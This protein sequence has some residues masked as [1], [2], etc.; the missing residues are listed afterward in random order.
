MAN[1]RSI[2]EFGEAMKNRINR[3]AE[4]LEL[5]LAF[6]VAEGV[7]EATEGKVP[8]R[9][10][11]SRVEVTVEDSSPENDIIDLKQHFR[12]SPNRKESL[13]GGWHMVIPMRRYT[14]Q[15]RRESSSGMSSR[16]YRDLLSQ[17]PEGGYAELVSDYLYDNRAPGSMISE[18]NYRPRGKGITRMPRGAGGHQYVSF[19]TV[20]DKSHPA[21]WIVNR[22]GADPNNMSQEVR[23]VINEVRNYNFQKF[24]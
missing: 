15:S 24:L 11:R 3:A 16:L 8:V 19:R 17:R 12:Q 20:S 9:Q 23:R 22:S 18:L 1:Y 2:D 10:R 21:S 5:N 7:K 13:D 4:Q 6:D 14:G